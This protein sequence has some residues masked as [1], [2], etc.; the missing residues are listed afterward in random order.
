MPQS[1][2]VQI[3]AASWCGYCNAA[4]RL[5]A[6]RQVPYEEI[7]V[8]DDAAARAEAAERYDWPTVPIVVIDGERLGGYTELAAL[9][10]S[11]GLQHLA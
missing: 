6:D 10:Q 2:K 1:P 3:Y 9:D 8:T 11:Q 4:K 5:L 7:D